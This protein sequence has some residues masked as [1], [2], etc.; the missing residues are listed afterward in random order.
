VLALLA[1]LPDSARAHVAGLYRDTL[2]VQV[3]LLSCALASEAQ[4]DAP[5][6]AGAPEALAHKLAGSA[7]MMQ[8]ADLSQLA[9]AME[10]ALRAGEP[11]AALA[12]LPALE[13]CAAQSLAEL[14]APD[15][16]AAAS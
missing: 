8:D 9:R 15:T 16:P 1:R 2:E 6:E 14:G 3:P 5:G 7:A 12:L 13:V 11:Q 4:S 10:H